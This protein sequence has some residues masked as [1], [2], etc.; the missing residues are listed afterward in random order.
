MLY[1]LRGIP[2]NLGRKT[3]QN[4]LAVMPQYPSYP[5]R[6]EEPMLER[7]SCRVT[8]ESAPDH[9][10]VSAVIYKSVWRFG[11]PT[12]ILFRRRCNSFLVSNNYTCNRASAISKTKKKWIKVLK[13]FVWFS[14]L[15]R[16]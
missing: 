1:Y 16:I 10:G 8:E 4:L 9:F 15:I 3:W 14:Y 5:I 13:K 2:Y 6:A 7:K 12:D 11:V